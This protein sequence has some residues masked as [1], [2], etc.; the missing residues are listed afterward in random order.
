MTAEK[1]AGYRLD[2]VDNDVDLIALRESWNSLLAESQDPT[3]FQTWEW[4]TSWWRHRAHN[5]VLWILVA[6]DAIGR[7][8]G[9]APWMLTCQQS[10]PLRVRRIGFIGSGIAYPA[11]LDIIARPQD[12]RGVTSAFLYYL[13]EHRG[14]WD[15]VDM[16]SISKQALLGPGIVAAHGVWRSK[17]ALVAPFIPL[18]ATWEIYER[19]K[20]STSHRQQIRTRRRRLFARFRR[21]GG[22]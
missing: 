18:P 15:V 19:E 10:G 5:E 6:R 13:E 9:I 1:H 22:V 8:V 2:R 17:S 12:K 3:I 11:H 20:L 7:A 4:I 16:A 21:P 14:E